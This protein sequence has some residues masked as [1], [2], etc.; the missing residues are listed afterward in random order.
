MQAAPQFKKKKRRRKKNYLLRLAAIIA[1]G[2]G[3]YFLV[4]SPLFDLQRVAVENNNYYTKEQIISKADARIGQNI[5]KVKT[6]LIKE[7]LLADPY[8]KNA[9]V[10]RSLPGTVVIIVEERAESA[11]IPYSDLYVI[12]DGDGMV[13]R[14]SDTEPKLPVLAGLTIK[15]MNEGEPLEVEETGALTGS[16]K[17]IGAMESAGIYFRKIEISNLVVKAYIYNY[18]QLICQGTPE[19]ILKGMQN[20]NLGTVLYELYTKGTERG[21]IIVGSGNEFPFSPMVE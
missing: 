13:L 5:F 4:A 8:I 9:R 11:A 10:K 14:R 19:N 16:L 1:L 18:E 3:T 6:G 7:A 21:I 2:V 20:G 12:I 15:A 17:I